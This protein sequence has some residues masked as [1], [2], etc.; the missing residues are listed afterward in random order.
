MKHLIITLLLWILA[1]PAAH[2]VNITEITSANKTYAWLIEDHS[3]PVISVRIAFR[4]AGTS[5]TSSSTLGL[6]YM[7]AEILGK[8]AGNLDHQ[9]FRQALEEKAIQLDFDVDTDYFYVSLKTL[10]KYKDAAFSLMEAALTRPKLDPKFIRQ[11][12]EQMGTEFAQQMQR[13]Q[14]IA[15]LKW[16]R[17]IFGEHPY[18]YTQYGSEKTRRNITAEKLREFMK[19]KFIRSNMLVS[20]TG[21]V[22]K[23]DVIGLLDN[24]LA[25]LPKWGTS[26]FT[27]SYKLF[28]AYPESAQTIHVEK[29]LPQSV[30][31]FSLPGVPFDSPDFYAAYLLNYILGGGG[32]ESRLM[33]E[34][35]EKRGLAYS[36]N[37]YL[38][39][40]DHAAI[41][42]GSVGT[43]S[44]HINTSVQLIKEQIENLQ[45]HGITEEELN[46]A[47]RYLIGSFPLRMET[48]E[49]LLNFL[50]FMQ[51]ENL[52]TDFI[53]TRNNFINAVTKEDVNRVARQLM[54]SSKLVTVIVGK[55]Q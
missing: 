39:N 38:H 42:K 49:K 5:Y 36:V 43:Q 26:H 16:K 54:D 8:G 22:T 30:A 21:D 7:L 15:D 46:S 55:K 2:A 35:R 10:S 33:Q 48:S 32:F 14:Y 37:S 47:K 13:P 23:T 12:N 19:E 51:I 27:T 40:L 31:V 25:Y 18:G 3:L 34:I 6:P 1:A 24:T 28:D 11:I 50:T 9:S 53:N 52:P 29:N 45:Q 41:L 20:V 4:H 17:T 44:D